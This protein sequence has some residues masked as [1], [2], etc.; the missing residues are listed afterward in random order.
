ME[1]LVNVLSG[2]CYSL[3]GLINPIEN[4]FNYNKNTNKPTINDVVLSGN[5]TS[6]DL[7]L[8]TP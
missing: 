1:N 7:G 6:E 5:L 2:I 8:I 3:S 4:S